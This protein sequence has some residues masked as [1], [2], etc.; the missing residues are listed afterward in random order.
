MTDHILTALYLMLSVAAAWVLAGLATSVR[1]LPKV[2]DLTIIPTVAGLGSLIFTTY[3]AGRRFGPDRI[4]RL[5]LFGTTVG[6]LG[7]L[8]LLLIALMLDVL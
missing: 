8:G 6:G 5:S 7:G 2:I 3:G 1:L 4:G